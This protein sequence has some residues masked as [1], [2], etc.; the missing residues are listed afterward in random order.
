MVV[1]ATTI[2]FKAISPDMIQRYLWLRKPVVTFYD[3]G[4]SF[5]ITFK[6]FQPVASSAFFPPCESQPFPYIRRI[7]IHLLSNI[8]L[9]GSRIACDQSKMPSRKAVGRPFNQAIAH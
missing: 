1:S 9:Q 7:D 5:S 2:G 8:H 6:H 3:Y 4:Q